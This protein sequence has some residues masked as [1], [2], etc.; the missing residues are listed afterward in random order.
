MYGVL[1]AKNFPK[2]DDCVVNIEHPKH[3]RTLVAS[4]GEMLSSSWPIFL[5]FL[6]PL[7]YFVCH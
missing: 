7:L 6:F 1:K 5:S 4:S 2:T 3:R